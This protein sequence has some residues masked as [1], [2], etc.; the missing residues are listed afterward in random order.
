MIAFKLI[1][2]E[3]VKKQSLH[4]TLKNHYCNYGDAGNG[5]ERKEYLR[6]YTNESEDINEYHWNGNTHDND[7]NDQ[8]R[9]LDEAMKV[10]KTP[11]PLTL[12][13]GVRGDP[14]KRANALG[15]VKHPAY[16]STSINPKIAKNFAN[17]QIER[18]YSLKEGHTHTLKIHVPQGHPGA[19]VAHI[20]EMPNEKEF[21]LPRESNLRLL[22]HKTTKEHHAIYGDVTH[23]VHTAEV[24]P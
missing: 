23:H 22:G 8:T 15:I 10:H 6:G 14:R 5:Y 24:V 17:S 18:S 20:S 21:I 4:T 12:Y 9:H 3:V 1:H 11:H 19:Y 16:L 7:K 13:S 2:E